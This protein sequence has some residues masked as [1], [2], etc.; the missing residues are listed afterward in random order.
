MNIHSAIPTSRGLN[1]R[2]WLRGLGVA[3]GVPALESFGA[4]PARSGAVELSGTPRRIAFLYA[5]NGRHMAEWT[6]TGRGRDWQL[7]ST[8]A[9]LAALKED[10]T[11]ISGLDHEQAKPLGD[12]SGGHSRAGATFLTGVHPYKTPGP[13]IRGGTSADQILAARLG[14]QT[15]LA[16]LE[17]GTDAFRPTG[18]CDAGYACAYQYNLS[19]RSPTAPV[20]A[21]TRPRAV[22]ERLFGLG[23][24]VSAETSA[25][26]IRARDERLA[27]RR[28]VL[29]YVLGEVKSLQNQISTPDKHALS[30]YLDSLREVERRLDQ[31]ARFAANVP[32]PTV[33]AP[34][35]GEPEDFAEH[36]RL[37]FD[38]LALAFQTDAT[39]IA[40]FLM[41]CEA[42]GRA[43]PGLG[44]NDGH[45]TLSHHQGNA[46]SL[47]KLAQIDRWYVGEVGRFLQRLKDTPI[48]TGGT[49][50]DHSMIIYGC[51]LADGNGHSNED[52]PILLAGRGGGTLQPGQHLVLDGAQPFMNLTRSLMS[53]MGAPVD[54][55]GDS[56]AELAGI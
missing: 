14:G 29:D 40:T 49:L 7:S 11:V 41:A 44:I 26:E 21:E 50:L 38:L 17:L 51:G 12:G 55:I 5:P 9:P 42:S 15:R 45:H 1:R 54:S 34:P 52:L 20:P 16:S 23:G 39:R 35:E 47:A 6:P 25:S 24:S 46:D 36:I 18:R 32:P 22:F 28:S 30:D 31:S 3:L 10:I 33:V 37:Q 56:T 2:T 48:P 19:W 43:F 8:L 13:D 27:T 53:R 4:A